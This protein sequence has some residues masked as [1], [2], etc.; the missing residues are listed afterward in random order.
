M[1]CIQHTTTISCIEHIN[2]N[3]GCLLRILALL[4]PRC[5]NMTTCSPYFPLGVRV[6]VRL[7]DNWWSL[8]SPLP[9]LVQLDG[10][11]DLPLDDCLPLVCLQNNSLLLPVLH[12]GCDNPLKLLLVLCKVP[13]CNTS[14]IDISSLRHSHTTALKK[15]YWEIVEKPNWYQKLHTTQY[16]NQHLNQAVIVPL[17]LKTQYG[18][19][20]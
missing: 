6:R 7:L 17:Q 3:L 15:W 10:V 13:P 14:Y 9:L 11:L 2:K 18:P 12:G 8:M 16:I 1:C 4:P 19:S 5:I 20:V